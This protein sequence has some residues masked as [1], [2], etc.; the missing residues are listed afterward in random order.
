[1][2]TDE[3]AAVLQVSADGNVLS[4]GAHRTETCAVDFVLVEKSSAEAG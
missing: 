3:I 1:M 2:Q 4:S